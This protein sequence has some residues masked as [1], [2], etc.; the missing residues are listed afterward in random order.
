VTFWSELLGRRVKVDDEWHNGDGN[1]ELAL[2]QLWQ[3]GETY[4]EST[5]RHI[6]AGQ[7][8]EQIDK[9]ALCCSLDHANTADTMGR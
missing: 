5:S 1:F 4:L 2:H 8:S 7:M 3:L 6:R 9:Y